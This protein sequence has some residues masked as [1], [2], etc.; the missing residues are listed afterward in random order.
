MKLTVLGSGSSGNG[1]VLQNDNEALVVECG[2]SVASMKKALDF[3]VMKLK[4]CL[5]SHGHGDH[6]KQVQKYSAFAPVYMSAGTAEEIGVVG[7][8]NIVKMKP[9]ELVKIGRFSVIPFDVYHDSKEPLGFFIMHDEIGKLLFVTDTAF[10]KYK[11]PGLT[12]IMI[13]ANF[14]EGIL[15]GNV[16]SGTIHP[17]LAKRIRKSHLSL[18]TCIEALQANDLSAVNNIVLLHLSDD[19][20]DEAMFRKTV[21]AST[22]KKTYIAKKGLEIEFNKEF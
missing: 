15:D 18:T 11:V 12:N 7:N 19:N 4:G 5:V 10:L 9:L 16:K 14:D 6:A 13:E 22:G 3:N 2:M 21:E 8:R 20:A 17:S 1:Y